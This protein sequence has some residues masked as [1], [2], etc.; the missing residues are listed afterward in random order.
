MEENIPKRGGL[1]SREGRIR[2]RELPVAGV[3]DSRKMDLT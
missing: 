2:N 3:N 1:E